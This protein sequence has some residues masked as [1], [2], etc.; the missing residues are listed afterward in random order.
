MVFKGF[1]E[2]VRTRGIIGFAIGYIVGKA[3]SDLVGSF[4]NDIL[5][6]IIGILLGS[7]KNLS[8]FSFTI[9]SAQIKY[10]SFLNVL[11][12]FIAISFITYFIFTILRFERL[13]MPKK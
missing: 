3:V 2:F 10:G 8:E 12:N 11:I 5:N 13:D 1:I 9:L 6:P 7:F 4:V